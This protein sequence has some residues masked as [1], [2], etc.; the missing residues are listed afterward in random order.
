MKYKILLPL[1]AILIFS[2]I[3]SYAITLHVGSGKTYSNPTLAANIAKAGDTILI[4]PGTYQGAF[5]ISNLKGKANAWI[6]I[7]GVNKGSVIFKAGSESFHFS[8]VSYIKIQDMTITG[9]T[10]NGMNIDDAGTLETPAHHVLVTH[11]DFINMGAQGNNDFLKV[12][13]L[14]SFEVSYCSFKNGA[15]GGS[16][17][18]MVGC[19]YGMVHHCTFDSLGSNSIQMK[20][21]TRFIR[22]ENNTFRD[23][24]QRALNL[25]GS[26]GLAFFRPQNATHEA[27]DISVYAN[28]FIKSQAPIAFVGSER[29]D[30]ANNTIY[31]PEKWV[32]RILQETVDTTRF[33]P[34]QNGL[35]RNNIIYYTSAVTTHVNIGSN[36]SPQTFLFSHNLWYNSS[37]PSSSNPTLPTPETNAI[38]GQD[39]LFT[40]TENFVLKTGSPAIQS[41]TA[42]S[43]LGKDMQGF[44]FKNPPSRGAYENGSGV[45]IKNEMINNS[46]SIYPNPVSKGFSVQS[47]KG[48]AICKIINSHGQIIFEKEINEANNYISFDGISEGIYCV[49][50]YH[51]GEKVVVGRLVKL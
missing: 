22:I 1:T 28:V 17:I 12:S 16:G 48:K 15:T 27:A 29:V 20:G 34:C 10:A 13:G 3:K 51:E 23:G 26:T 46:L 6:V 35:F 19:H 39:P 11:C 18:D 5:F 43:W 50:I 42:I 38:K 14:D 37:N 49:T 40:S 8:D 36:T 31:M 4:H 47:L 2:T 7:K 21:G 33:V 30:V 44:N 45:S 25:G 24:G 32:I 41:G 9:H